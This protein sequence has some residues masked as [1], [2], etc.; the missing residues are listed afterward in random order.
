MNR[1]VI[2]E[3]LRLFVNTLTANDKYS[4]CNRENLPQPILMKLSQTETISPYFFAAFMKYKSSF[5]HLGKQTYPHRSPISKI[6]DCK[7]RG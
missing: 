2:C 6:T 7:R 3:I 4:L 1:L 5:E